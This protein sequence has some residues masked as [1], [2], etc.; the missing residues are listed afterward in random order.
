MREDLSINQRMAY[1]ALIESA[2]SGQIGNN[3]VDK[4]NQKTALVVDKF[5]KDLLKKTEKLIY[6][7]YTFR[8]FKRFYDTAGFTTFRDN[9]A[10]IDRQYSGYT[11]VNLIRAIR[12]DDKYKI[13]LKKIADSYKQKLQITLLRR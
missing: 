10:E 6:S 2:W 4:V 7:D 12:R 13:Y 9:I 5:L 3:Y 8:R 1:S 11:I